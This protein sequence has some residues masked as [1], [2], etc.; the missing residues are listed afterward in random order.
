MIK[1][2]VWGVWRNQ[3]PFYTKPEDANL[4]EDPEVRAKISKTI[5]ELRREK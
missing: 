2:G 3:F 1:R 5:I 4:P